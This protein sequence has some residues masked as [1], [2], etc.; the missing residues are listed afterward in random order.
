MIVF[1]FNKYLY[2]FCYL[3]SMVLVLI[4]IPFER[5]CKNDNDLKIKR[6]NLRL[7][8]FAL[9]MLW[10]IPLIWKANESNGNK[11]FLMFLAIFESS[12]IYD[13]FKD[14][15]EIKGESLSCLNNRFLNKL[16]KI[17]I[18][19]AIFSIAI[20]I[21]IQ[22]QFNIKMRIVLIISLLVIHEALIFLAKTVLKKC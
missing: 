22:L 17:L 13:S 15:L 11:H 6:F 12:L 4:N 3:S 7:N 14:L 2:S 5:K 1:D 21:F 10:S 18:L 8:N 20:R 16:E 9:L 19:I